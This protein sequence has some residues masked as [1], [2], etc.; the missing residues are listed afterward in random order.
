MRRNSQN[1]T[2][3]QIFNPDLKS[4]C[5]VSYSNTNFDVTSAKIYS[6]FERKTAFV[7]QNFQNLGYSVGGGDHDLRKPLKGTSFTRFE[8]LCVRIG[9]RQSHQLEV[10][11]TSLFGRS[12]LRRAVTSQ[13]GTQGRHVG[14]TRRN[15]FG[16]ELNKSQISHLMAR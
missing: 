11:P 14:A 13:L 2:F 9:S 10:W 3:R 16:F 15:L 5:S 1:S 4:P 12:R 6:C 8:P 7:M